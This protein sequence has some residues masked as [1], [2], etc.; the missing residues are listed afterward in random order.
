MKVGSFILP[1]LDH[2]EPAP[3]NHL[4]TSG[5]KSTFSFPSVVVVAVVVVVER[6]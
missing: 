2:D 3:F 5:E 1:I 6:V 4:W